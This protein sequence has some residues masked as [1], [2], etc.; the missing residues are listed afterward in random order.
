[1]PVDPLDNK[2]PDVIIRRIQEDNPGSVV[3]LSDLLVLRA[4]KGDEQALDTLLRQLDSF[5]QQ[6][7]SRSACH[8]NDRDDV[9]QI[10]RVTV[11][12]KIRMFRGT[13]VKE[14]CRWVA[15]IIRTSALNVS[16]GYRSTEELTEAHHPR[17]D[18][19]ADGIIEQISNEQILAAVKGLDP[20]LQLVLHYRY[21]LDL[22]W[23]EVAC[24]LRLNEDYKARRLAKKALQI[25][26]T[27]LSEA[28][29]EV[30]YSDGDQDEETN[31]EQ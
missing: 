16:R 19:F 3:Q 14:F 5:M 15:E 17:E 25:L 24:L 21:R 28:D 20:Q 9:L 22:A 7:V 27:G 31:H 29:E 11:F 2:P 1:M 30:Q 10:V 4:K 23:H 12:L 13:T 26:R 6:K 18:D 8:Q